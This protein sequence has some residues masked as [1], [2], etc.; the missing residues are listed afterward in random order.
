[1][2]WIFTFG[3]GQHDPRTGRELDDRFVR[4]EADGYYQARARMLERF[5]DPNGAGNW[6][7]DYETEEDAGVDRYRIIEIDFETGLDIQREAG[8]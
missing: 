8:Q 5:G 6:A 3:Y 1:M 2:T 4:V 7:F